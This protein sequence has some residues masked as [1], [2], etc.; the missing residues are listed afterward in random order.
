MKQVRIFGKVINKNNVKFI[1]K[2]YKKAFKI[3]LSEAPKPQ[4]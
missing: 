4:R 3:R 2:L 1:I